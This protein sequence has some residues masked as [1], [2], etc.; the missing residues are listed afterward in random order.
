[1]SLFRKRAAPAEVEPVP[2]VV[3]RSSIDGWTLDG[4]PLAA[5]VARGDRRELATLLHGVAVRVETPW[6]YIRAVEL[7]EAAH[8]PAQA[9]A[10][11]AAWL[12]LPAATRP[13]HAHDTRTLVRAQDRLRVRLGVPEGS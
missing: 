7:L 5:S 2:L 8:E 6:T 9:Y 13:G 10:V 11:C 12:A 4:T 3:P 1:V